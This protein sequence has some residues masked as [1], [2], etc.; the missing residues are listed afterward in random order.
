MVKDKFDVFVRGGLRE[1]TKKIV[2]SASLKNRI[3][4]RTVEKPNTFY[5]KFRKFMNTT[6]VIPL[7]SALAICLIMIVFTFSAF[8]VTDSMKKD[9][10]ILGYSSIKIVKMGGI[11]VIVDDRDGEKLNEKY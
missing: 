9:K 8:R 6:I 1:E 11:D 7:P 4:K 5:D 3:I 2:M 10:S